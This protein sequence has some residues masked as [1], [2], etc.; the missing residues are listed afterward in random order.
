MGQYDQGTELLNVENGSRI[1]KRFTT[2]QII[3]RDSALIDYI[4]CFSDDILL[5]ERS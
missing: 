1:I 2:I 5:E 4:D 3:G